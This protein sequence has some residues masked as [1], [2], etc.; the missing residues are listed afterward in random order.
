MLP[1]R[2]RPTAS[3]QAQNHLLGTPSVPRS[4]SL[5]CPPLRPGLAPPPP[6][7]LK[8]AA[9]AAAVVAEG[10]SRPQGPFPVRWWERT[11]RGWGVGVQESEPAAGP[12]S[13]ST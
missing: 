2:A 6:A 10:L 4:P 3:P 1:V 5:S 12:D 13:S 11:W 7:H 8:V 9:A